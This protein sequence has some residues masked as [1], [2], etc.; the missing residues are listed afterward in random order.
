[1]LFRPHYVHNY[2]VKAIPQ[3]MLVGGRGGRQLFFV[4]SLLAGL[5]SCDSN[6]ERSPIIPLLDAKYD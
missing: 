1:M 6:D 3:N 2:T 5:S 4:S